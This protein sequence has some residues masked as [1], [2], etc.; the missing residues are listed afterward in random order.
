MSWTLFW[1]LVMLSLL[2]YIFV[3]SIIDKYFDEKTTSVILMETS[4][5]QILRDGEARQIPLP[6]VPLGPAPGAPEKRLFER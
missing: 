1:Q 3:W 5:S 4:V 6:Q 2:L